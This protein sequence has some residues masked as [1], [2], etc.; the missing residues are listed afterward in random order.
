LQCADLTKIYFGYIA[1]LNG[2]DWAALGDFVDPAVVHNGRRLGIEGYRAMLESDYRLIPDLSFVVEQLV[3]NA[4]FV[5]ARLKFDC[6]PKGDFLGLNVDGR[7]VSFAEHAIY[8]FSNGTI[9][10]VWSVIDKQAVEEQLA[11]RG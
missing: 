2:R 8:A 6:T 11:S 7:K 10:E 3:S 4:D 9:T 1:C 5:A